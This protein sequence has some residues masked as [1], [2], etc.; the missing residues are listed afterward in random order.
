MSTLTKRGYRGHCAVSGAAAMLQQY[1]R[2]GRLTE[3]EALA[4]RHPKVSWTQGW[5]ECFGN[6]VHATRFGMTV[7]GS[8]A[9]MC[10]LVPPM[11]RLNNLG[12]AL[13]TLNN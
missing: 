1:H 11:L 8:D 5:L 7:F 3:A 9:Q 2:D 10:E 13:H 6:P 4:I 12:W